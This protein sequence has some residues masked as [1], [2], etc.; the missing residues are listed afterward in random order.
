MG[1]VSERAGDDETLSLAKN[2]EGVALGEMGDVGQALVCFASSL[3]NAEKVGSP[4]RQASALGNA[5]MTLNSIGLQREAIPCLYRSISLNTQVA[6]THETNLAQSYL[7]LRQYGDGIE[8]IAKSIRDR[9]EAEDALTAYGRCIAEFTYAQLALA[10]DNVKLAR[11]RSE[12]CLDYS[13][14]STLRAAWLANVVIALCEVRSGSA[15]VGIRRLLQTLAD[16]EAVLPSAIDS[17]TG[18]VQAYDWIGEPDRALEYLTRLL[19]MIRASRAKS[20]EGLLAWSIA[21][22]GDLPMHLTLQEKT[23]RMRTAEKRAES[24]AI[25]MLER[26][27][28]TADLKDDS[29]GEHGYRVG[30]ISR[31]FAESLGWTDSTARDLELAAR[32]HDIGK[33]VVPDAILRHPGKLQA[34][35]QALMQGHCEAGAAMLAN[36]SVPCVRLAESIARC[37]HEAWDGS[38]Y[39][40]ALRGNQIPVGARIVALADSFDALTHDRSYS[41]AWTFDEACKAIQEQAGKRFDPDL[42]RTF[43]ELV[44]GLRQRFGSIEAAFDGETRSPISKA[45]QRIRMAM[46]D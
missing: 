21:P 29:S 19:S 34:H 23:L 14:R 11:E 17:L 16:S 2:L 41:A 43:L 10:Q 22:A 15:K 36:S 9:P 4:V 27:A 8:V 31:I 45:R 5:G 1:Q 33:I 26:M 39:P 12:I 20:I 32:L 38:G 30:G 3:I 18:L 35:A 25:E 28:V 37:H 46:T 7:E 40:R 6:P 44:A 24:V 42:T 13:A